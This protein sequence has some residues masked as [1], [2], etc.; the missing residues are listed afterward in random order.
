MAIWKNVWVFVKGKVMI[1]VAEPGVVTKELEE[2]ATQDPWILEEERQWVYVNVH[3]YIKDRAG[4]VVE[5]EDRGAG[6]ARDSDD[7]K[8]L[9]GCNSAVRFMATRLQ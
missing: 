7:V 2:W 1:E 5:V 6:V 9:L 4:K 8:R 3:V